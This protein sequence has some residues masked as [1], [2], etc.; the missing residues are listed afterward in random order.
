LGLRHQ[1]ARE[2]SFGQ[3]TLVGA[4]ANKLG[5]DHTPDSPLAPGEP[6]SLLL[7]WRGEQDA[8]A[9][10]PLMLRLYSKQ[11]TLAAKWPFEATE[12]RHPLQNWTKEELVRDPQ[13]RFL[14]SDIAVGDYRLMLEGDGE[15]AL[16][17]KV[18]V[19]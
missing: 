2:I 8:P 13:V 1:E 18:S 10:Q 14:P 19:R 17:G 9:K 6:L 11:G 16:V 7:Y 5:F 3:I 4:R 15:E 12:T